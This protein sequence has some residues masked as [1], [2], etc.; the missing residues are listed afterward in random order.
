M[1]S[2]PSEMAQSIFFHGIFFRFLLSM[3][4]ANQKRIYKPPVLEAVLISFC[5]FFPVSLIKHM[6]F[7]RMTLLG[8]AREA[9]RDAHKT[10][11]QISFHGNNSRELFEIELGIYYLFCVNPLFR[12]LF[13]SDFSFFP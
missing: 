7:L 1:Y 2:P 8:E 10:P 3:D 4:A 9:M 6:P 13:D 11:Y 5:Q 12:A